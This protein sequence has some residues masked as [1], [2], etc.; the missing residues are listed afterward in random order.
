ML[1]HFYK[2]EQKMLKIK[3]EDID[4]KNVLGILNKYGKKLN[5]EGKKKIIRVIEEVKKFALENQRQ[6]ESFIFLYGKPAPDNWPNAGTI[7]IDAVLMTK[8]EYDS[9]IKDF[10]DL[11]QKELELD[12]ER[13]TIILDKKEVENLELEELL[14]A[15]LF[16][17]LKD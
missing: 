1:F 16:F 17:D 3:Q 5:L 8:E 12:W 11:S 13:K 2:K 6:K 7:V 14:V 10:Y 9:C 15:E 4:N